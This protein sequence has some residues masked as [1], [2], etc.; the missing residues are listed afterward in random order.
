MTAAVE[1][2]NFQVG[3]SKEPCAPFKATAKQTGAVTCSVCRICSTAGMELHRFGAQ[4]KRPVCPLCH[5]CLHL[6]GAGQRAT[7]VMIWLPEVSQP[8]LNAL[9]TTLFALV[10]GPT[11]LALEP[12]AQERMRNLYRTME[13]RVH[14][15]ESLFGNTNTL[16]NATSPLF[17]AQQISQAGAALKG[18]LEPEVLSGRLDGLRFLAREAPF[19]AFI[20]GA[21]RVLAK[22]HP[23]ESWLPRVTGQTEAPQ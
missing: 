15:V 4:G 3:V 6:D 20:K 19:S 14:P 7:G 13:S 22:R 11:R 12:D 8:Q 9:V 1:S 21:G 17:L 5:V 2:L 18:R 10:T 23:L 16:F